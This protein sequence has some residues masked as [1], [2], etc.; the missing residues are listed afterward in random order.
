[1]IRRAGSQ[2]Q[3]ALVKRFSAHAQT[4]Q[5]L[6]PPLT[7]EELGSSIHRLDGAGRAR[8]KGP[9][10][11][12]VLD[13]SGTTADAHTIAPT[14]V[15]NEVFERAGCPITVKEAREP[16]GIR[17]D[18][19]I[20][21]I[22]E[23]PAVAKR[24]EEN[25]GRPVDIEKD[26][27]KL[28]ADFIPRQLEVLDRYSTL[29]PGCAETLTGLQKQ[30]VKVGVTT[31]FS[32][33]MVDILLAS[34]EKQGYVPD[35]NVAGDDVENN[36]GY[37]P[38][39]FMVYKNLVNLGAWPIESVIKV[40]DCCSGVNEGINAGCWTVGVS[41]WSNYTEVESI[42]QWEAMSETERKERQDMSRQKLLK[43]SGAHYVADSIKDLPRIVEDV[44]RRLA[45]GE[46]P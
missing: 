23:M 37:R 46:K 30:G 38:A 44:N 24:W 20:K 22:L 15:F 43:E 10:T 11:A 25:V 33:A 2:L 12:V 17:K 34:A 29:L 14:I 3:R 26:T 8:F 31:G 42:E 16:M 4:S 21:A 35:Y 28:Y 39:P 6:L 36:M 1:M 41:D 5:T 7:D 27:A 32:R 19:H 9:V 18:L 13:W 45:L 40:D